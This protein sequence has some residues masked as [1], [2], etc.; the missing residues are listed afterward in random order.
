MLKKIYQFW[1]KKNGWSIKGD[2]HPLPDKFILIA[3][4]HTANFDF[5]LGVM[6]RSLLGLHSTKF[7]GKSQL[8]KWPYGFIF[9][10]MGGQPVVRTKDNNLVDAVTG[11]FNSREKFSIA[12]A[13]EGTRS[14][15]KRLKTGFYHIARKAKVPIY[16][17]GFDFST[18]TIIIRE[19][20]YPTDNI[21]EDFRLLISFYANIKGKY[22]ELGIDLSI[23]EST[24]EGQNL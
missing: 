1:F 4:P 2:F 13:P 24:V 10:A 3:A 5:I 16:P 19:P 15:V 23:L 18:K 11:M 7:L 22:P 12:L 21:K 17:V 9:R 8:F 6:A 14:K 20:L